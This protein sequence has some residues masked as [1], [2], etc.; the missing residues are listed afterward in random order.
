VLSVCVFLFLLLSCN[1]RV[2]CSFEPIL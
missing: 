2:L 1:P